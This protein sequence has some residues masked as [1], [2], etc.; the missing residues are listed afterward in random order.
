MDLAVKKIFGFGVT[1]LCLTSTQAAPTNQPD[2]CPNPAVIANIGV[3]QETKKDRKG[4]WY[5]IK[6]HHSY[7]TNDTWDFII[8]FIIATDK[9]D[10][11]QKAAA[12]LATLSFNRGPFYTPKRG[13]TCLYANAPGYLAAATISSATEQKAQESLVSTLQF[14]AIDRRQ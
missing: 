8:G 9:N 10:A 11:Y 12:A 14:S 4:Q 6:Q 13:W 7:D 2:K 5:A 1:L 3:E